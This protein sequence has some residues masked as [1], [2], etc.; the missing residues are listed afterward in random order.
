MS[1]V[2]LNLSDVFFVNANEGWIAG[3]RG[4]LLHTTDGGATWE[5]VELSTH[6]NLSRLFFVAPDC[7]WVVGT[8]GA[9]F[10]YGRIR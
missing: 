3:D 5:S 9:I 4:L 7:G 2:E 1:N 8:S 10:K 6:A